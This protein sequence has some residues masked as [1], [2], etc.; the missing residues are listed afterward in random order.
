MTFT[1]PGRAGFEIASTASA[2]GMLR[3][4]SGSAAMRPPAISSAARVWVNG[5]M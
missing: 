3:E 2:S 5:L 1:S 4:M